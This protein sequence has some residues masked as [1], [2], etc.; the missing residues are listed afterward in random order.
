MSVIWIAALIALSITGACFRMLRKLTSA[1]VSSEDSNAWTDI[2][3]QSCRPLDRLLDP[4]EFEFLQKRGLSKTRIR[5]L[6]ATRRSLFRMYMR[7]LTRE[8]NSAH[9]ALHSVLVTATFD[10]P[11]LVRELGRQKLL[12]YRGLIGVGVRLSLNALGFDSVPMPSLAL[13]RPLER[14]HMECCTLLPELS[15]AQA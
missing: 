10:R 5:Q 9:S 3:W 11:D 6:R 8:F 7:R 15:A 13:I 4:A 1:Q 14:L 2:N 12:F